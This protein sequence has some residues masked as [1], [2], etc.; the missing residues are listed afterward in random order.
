M[1]LQSKNYKNTYIFWHFTCWHEAKID[2]FCT[3]SFESSLNNKRLGIK[4]IFNGL[5]NC[6]FQVSM[7]LSIFSILH[8]WIFSDGTSALYYS[9]RLTQ[10]TRYRDITQFPP[11]YYPALVHFIRDQHVRKETIK[12]RINSTRSH[13]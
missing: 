11:S 7:E 2:D 4:A 8:S 1:I 13:V 3:S 5:E 10:F 12:R 9:Q 6:V